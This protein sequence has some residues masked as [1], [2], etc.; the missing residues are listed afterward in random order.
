[1]RPAAAGTAAPTAG[2]DD[3]NDGDSGGGAGDGGG[4]SGGGGDDDDGGGVV[5]HLSSQR[6]DSQLGRGTARRLAR[7][8]ERR[9]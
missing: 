4:G 3:G 7:G 8:G 9:R 2:V 1:M 6:V 5:L